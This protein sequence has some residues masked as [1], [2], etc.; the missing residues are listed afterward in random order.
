MHKDLVDYIMRWAAFK[1]S[2][3]MWGGLWFLFLLKP[4]KPNFM[5]T[6]LNTLEHVFAR[7]SFVKYFHEIRKIGKEN[8]KM[9]KMKKQRGLEWG[10]GRNW[11]RD[12]RRRKEEEV[13]RRWREERGKKRGF[14]VLFASRLEQ[15]NLCMTCALC[16]WLENIGV[17]P[18]MQKKKKKKEW[19]PR[20]R[21]LFTN[22]GIWGPI[23]LNQSPRGF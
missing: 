13:E 20:T 16:K 2:T 14:R 18:Y 1:I 19:A 22:I 7:Q 8:E 9:G 21:T 5:I 10:R 4:S 15:S 23:L 17:A 3:A 11:S 6:G 12:H